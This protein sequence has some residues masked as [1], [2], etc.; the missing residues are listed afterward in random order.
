M[1]EEFAS[2]GTTGLACGCREHGGQADEEEEIRKDEVGGSDAVPSGVRKLVK[3]RGADLVVDDDHE[4]DGETAQDVDGQQ[5]LRLCEG[6]SCDDV[7]VDAAGEVWIVIGHG[8]RPV[9]SPSAWAMAK[10]SL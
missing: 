5:A 8:L 3:G 9:A 2:R 1:Q 6:S 7:L 4:R 10:L